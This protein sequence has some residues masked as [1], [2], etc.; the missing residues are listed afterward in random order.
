MGSWLQTKP[1]KHETITIQQYKKGT[2]KELKMFT[3]FTV[4][5][6][7]SSKS[8]EACKMLKAEDTF[9]SRI[10]C[11]CSEMK[12]FLC[13]SP[14]WRKFNSVIF[15]WNCRK[16]TLN[17]AFLTLALKGDKWPASHC[18]HCNWQKTVSPYPLTRRYRGPKNKNEYDKRGSLCH[19]QKSYLSHHEG[20][21]S[22]L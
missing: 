1:N 13:L 9:V 6:M 12:R 21:S 14:K 11:E 20:P 10:N 19:R 17:K 15:G 18:S 4:W 8:Q 2:W 22:H 5:T 7:I 16:W 3:S